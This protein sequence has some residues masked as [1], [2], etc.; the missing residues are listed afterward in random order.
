M[1][2][3][4]WSAS[5]RTTLA[6]SGMAFDATLVVA[7][8]AIALAAGL[9][10]FRLRSRMRGSR[11]MV[12]TAWLFMAGMQVGA[13][14]WA[15]HTLIMLAIHPVAALAHDPFKTLSSLLLCSGGGV[16]ALSVAWTGRDLLR[17]IAGGLI[18]GLTLATSHFI[19]L[20]SLNVQGAVTFEP[21][22]TWGAVVLATLSAT[23]AF[24]AGERGQTYLRQIVGAGLFALAAVGMQILALSG[25]TITADPSMPVPLSLMS[26]GFMLIIVVMVSVPDPALRGRRGLHRRHER[27][28]LPAPH[29]PPRRRRPRRH[30]GDGRGRLHPRLQRRL[31]HAPGRARRRHHRPRLHRAASQARARR[32]PGGR[33]AADR[34]RDRRRGAHPGGDLRPAARRD[35]PRR[36]GLDGRRPARPARASGSRA[37]HPAPERPRPAHRPAEPQR[38]SSHAGERPRPGLRQQGDADGDQHRDRQL[39]RDGGGLRPGRGRRAPLQDRRAAAAHRHQA[40]LRRPPARRGLHLRRLRP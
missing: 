17:V 23:A 11:G 16:L 25:A 6:I 2:L 34:P 5:V 26:P 29:P 32:Q 19:G 10:L 12:R 14:I 3:H 22:V 8:V 24:A 37:P 36:A 7:A 18:V 15:A 40:R 35:A 31:R 33:G 39:S 4:T 21:I 9:G 20:S 28:Q 13:G 38:P 30:R 27:R 1:T